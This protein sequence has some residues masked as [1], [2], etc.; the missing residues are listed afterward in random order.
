MVKHRGRSPE[1]PGL[2]S[3][4]APS[5]MTVAEAIA[6]LG[7]GKT[8]FY[9]LMKE[10]RIPYVEFGSVRRIRTDDLADVLRRGTT[11][12]RRMR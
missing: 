8:K 7:C 2:Y 11:R 3:T 5:W 12:K 9:A 6:A 10:G 4:I 1:H